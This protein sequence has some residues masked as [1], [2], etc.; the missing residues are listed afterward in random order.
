MTGKCTKGERTKINKW[1]KNN[2]DTMH[3]V[4]NLSDIV[5]NSEIDF[6]VGDK[7]VFTNEYGISF[8]NLTI[9]AISKDDELFKWGK[10]IFLNTST[11]WHAVHPKS[12]SFNLPEKK[13]K[14]YKGLT[15]LQYNYWGVAVYKDKY[16]RLW[17][18]LGDSTNHDF[19]SVP[20]NDIDGD[21]CSPITSYYP[22]FY[23]S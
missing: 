20:S 2:K 19:Y 18:D 1:L 21:A 12:L 6:K 16:G 14:D 23:N 3:F 15:F 13:N 17:Q 8:P 11:Y 5:P 10:C 7:V 22:N 4:Q 9:V